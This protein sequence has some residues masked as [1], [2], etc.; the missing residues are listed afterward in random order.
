LALRSQ[1]GKKILKGF[2]KWEE[3]NPTLISLKK[4]WCGQSNGGLEEGSVTLGARAGLLKRRLPKGFRGE[5]ADH[6]GINEGGDLL[7]RIWDSQ[8]T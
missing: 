8:R 2:K 1:S 3:N 4:G 6:T 5:H 7:G